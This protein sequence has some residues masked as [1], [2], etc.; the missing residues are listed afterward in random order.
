MRNNFYDFEYSSYTTLV[1]SVRDCQQSV[2]QRVRVSKYRRFVFEN[3]KTITVGGKKVGRTSWNE[4]RFI[5]DIN[6]ADLHDSTSRF[7][8]I[9]IRGA[10][11]SKRIG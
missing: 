6:E 11:A 5:L 7:R 2:R 8:G 10:R 9:Y 3:K 1:C 4:N